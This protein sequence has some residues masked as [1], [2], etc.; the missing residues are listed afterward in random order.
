MPAPTAADLMTRGLFH[1]RIIPPLSSLS[2]S[3][4]MKKVIAFARKEMKKD[5]KNR[6]RSRLVKHSVPKMKHLRRH[7]GI[8]NPY[9]QA[10]LCICVARNWKKLDAICQKSSLS[11]SRASPSAKR[12]LAA[13]HSRRTEGVCRAQRSVGRRFMLKADI[14]TF[15]PSIYTHS[16]PWAIHGKETARSKRAGKWYGNQLDIWTRDTQDRQTGGIPIGPDTS[17]LIAEVIAS[18]MD[19]QL[20]KMLRQE[21][22]GV[23]Y[24]DDYH[25]YFA[26]R[27]DAERALAALHTVTQAF[28]LQLN[29]PKTEIVEVP[30]AIEPRW[31]TELRLIDIQSDERATGVKAYFDRACE[32]A[33]QFPSDSV[34]TYAVRKITRYASRLKVHEWQVCRS[35]LLRSCLGEATML[36]ALL[37]LFV[38]KPEA[39]E[40]NDLREVLV[41]LCL[42]HAPLQQGFEVAWSLWV[43]RALKVDLPMSVGTAVRKIDDDIVALVALDMQAEGLLPKFDSPLWKSRMSAD[44]LYSEHWL[45]AYEALAQGWLPPVGG[46]DYLKADPFFSILAN[47]AVRF[48]NGEETWE[49][50]YSD[51]SDDDYEEDADEDDD[52]DDEDDTGDDD[53]PDLDLGEILI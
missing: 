9:S 52:T 25:L 11:L 27:T 18:R 37:E 50:G 23:R 42:Y 32:L 33:I 12:A 14:A 16:I 19:L 24:I 20:S 35:L 22:K 53:V 34:F 41:E 49:D 3:G 17:F 29:A 15:Y 6:K 5:S 28:E 30:E 48:Y 51:Y 47:S 7:F 21:L 45:L 40:K 10:M 8:P 44:D 13:E 39:W 46:K 26:T 4:A 38:Q 43:A 2:L 1:D 31:K 36:P